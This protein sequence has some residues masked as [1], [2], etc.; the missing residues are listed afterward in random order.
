V[1]GELVSIANFV[2]NQYLKVAES[3]LVEEELK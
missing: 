1:A 3:R 2:W